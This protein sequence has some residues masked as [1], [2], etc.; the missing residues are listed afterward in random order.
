MRVVTID[1]GGL[2]SVAYDPPTRRLLVLGPHAPKWTLYQPV[3]AHIVS[4][5]ISSNNPA[6]VVDAMLGSA[7]PAASVITST[8]II[9]GKIT[10]LV[11]NANDALALW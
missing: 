2:I 1:D 6:V 9:S 5:L 3:D 11:L 8:G 4:D 10:F 7:V